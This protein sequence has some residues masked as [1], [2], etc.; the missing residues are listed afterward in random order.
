M[1]LAGLV[2]DLPGKCPQ[3]EGQVL[4]WRSSEESAGAVSIPA[5]LESHAARIRQQY[6]AF[7]HE[8]GELQVS[9]R[10]VSQHL[11]DEAGNNF[12]WMGLIAEKSPLKTPEIYQA[13]RLLA[14][15]DY[16]RSASQHTLHLHSDDATLACAVRALCD[17]LRIP[18][19]C[20]LQ[21]PPDTGLLER[22]RQTQN[23]PAS[24][25]APLEAMLHLRRRW[26]LRRI[27]PLRWHSGL[28]AVFFCSYF[29]HLDLAAANQGRFD[30]R[31][32][33]PL[34]ELLVQSGLSLNW[35][36]NYWPGEAAA[37]APAA[38]RRAG[39]FNA[40]AGAQG[41]HG[42]VDAYLSLRVL[43][44][45][46]RSWWFLRRQA[47]TLRCLPSCLLASGQA[48]Y[49][50][51]VL[52]SA[53]TSSLSGRVSVANCLSVHLFDAAMR[54]LPRQ[55]RGYYLFEN[56]AWEKA[57]LTAWRRHGHG[58]ITGVV[59]STVP[60]WH[61]YYAEDPRSLLPGAQP[62]PDAI[63][64]NGDVARQALLAQGYSA[65]RLVKAEA[66]RYLSLAQRPERDAGY[67][68]RLAAGLRVL[69]VGGMESDPLREVLGAVKLAVGL[70]P[71]GYQFDFKP[72]P[73]YLLDP[74]QA[75]GLDVPV[76]GGTLTA[77]LASYD[78]V[79][80]G[81]ST[82]ACVDAYLAGKPVIIAYGG[83]YLNLSPLRGQSGVA[84]FES[85]QQLVTALLASGNS[86]G[87]AGERKEYFYL[88][89]ELTRWRELLRLPQTAG[90]AN[91]TNGDGSDGAKSEHSF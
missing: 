87:R 27:R 28:D 86:Q 64:V 38:V 63:A 44:L 88:D 67:G 91:A 12:W 20:S 60:F 21:T 90:A 26:A 34:P 48:A 61:L 2:W 6:L 25:Q 30:S 22:F 85:P 24:L 66:L 57:F 43:V 75:V 50:W 9:G 80:A 56:Q 8:L 82:S 78:C 58:S 16:M 10:T 79:V 69:V 71:E 72:H 52:Q 23:W 13:L 4:L 1:S 15:E 51:P 41:L 46:M 3:F 76:V 55:S 11:Q 77:L 31:Q 40:V 29:A 83:T 36:H 18:F 39:R 70:L 17:R 73:A 74:K 7:V 68:G 53:W 14:L 84:F 45:A 5:Y 35:L 54:D 32:W 37:D 65:N 47:K 42:F 49:L 89:N 19:S 62:Q 59:H 81:N 33:G